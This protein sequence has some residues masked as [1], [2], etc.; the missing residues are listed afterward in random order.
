M[1]QIK[2]YSN[3]RKRTRGVHVRLLPDE[4]VVVIAN[5]SNAGLSA[6]GLMRALA[7]GYQPKS[8]L[9]HKHIIELIR[10]RGDLGRVGGLLKWWLSEDQS[11]SSRRRREVNRLRDTII[12]N[13]RELHLTIEKIKTSLK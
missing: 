7:T 1:A 5:A 11:L 12:A 3:K 4:E 8:V 6:A 10:L 2:K 13:Q 9:D